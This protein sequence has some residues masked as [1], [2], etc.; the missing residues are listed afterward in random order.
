MAKE[1]VDELMHL[2]QNRQN[3]TQETRSRKIRIGT[4]LLVRQSVAV[5]PGHR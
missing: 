4:K 1:A 5:A 3:V 2:I